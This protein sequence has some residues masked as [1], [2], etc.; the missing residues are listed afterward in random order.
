M[1]VQVIDVKIVAKTKY[2]TD[3]VVTLI[4]LIENGYK[5]VTECKNNWTLVK[6]RIESSH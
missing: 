3:D 6:E 2:S 4:K 5:I 1:S